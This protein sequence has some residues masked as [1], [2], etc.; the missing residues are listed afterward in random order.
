MGNHDGKNLTALL[1]GFAIVTIG[2]FV[3]EAFAPAVMDWLGDSSPW[4]YGPATVVVWGIVSL[5]ARMTIR[6]NPTTDNVLPRA[7]PGGTWSAN[8]KHAFELRTEAARQLE[9]DKISALSAGFALTVLTWLIVL[10]Y[11]PSAWI[12]EIGAQ[13]PWEYSIVSI[14]YWAV[15]AEIS[16]LLLRRGRRRSDCEIESDSSA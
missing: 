4:V 12:E 7:V 5:I 3:L 10:S 15:T 11:A 9:C 14:V 8:E 13:P 1:I 16:Y 2:W 6:R